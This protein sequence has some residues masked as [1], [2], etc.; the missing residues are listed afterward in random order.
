MNS[1]E[2]AFTLRIPLAASNRG[3]LGMI[4]HAHVQGA[5]WG[6]FCC[7]SYAHSS[8]NIVP[9]TGLNFLIPLHH[10]LHDLKKPLSVDAYYDLPSGFQYM[11]LLNPALLGRILI[12][13]GQAPVAHERAPVDLTAFCSRAVRSSLVWRMALT[14]R[15]KQRKRRQKGRE[16]KSWRFCGDG[17]SDQSTT[18]TRASGS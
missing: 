3:W 16:T 8:P 11:G 15:I 2:S 13:K 18:T 7:S 4:L 10:I 17:G 6:S 14:E 9:F 5:L 12:Y 1:Y